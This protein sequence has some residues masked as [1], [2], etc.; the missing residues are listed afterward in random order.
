[1]YAV[2][3]TCDKLVKAGF[4]DWK[5]AFQFKIIMSRYDWTIKKV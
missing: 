2:Y 4:R 3:D 1:M 5:S